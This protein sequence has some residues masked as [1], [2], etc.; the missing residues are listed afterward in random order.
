[1]GRTSLDEQEAT[2]GRYRHSGAP[3][4]KKKEFDED[5]FKS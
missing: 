3:L 2:F 4:G 5:G 1:M